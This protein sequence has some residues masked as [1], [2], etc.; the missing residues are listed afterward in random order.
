MADKTKRLNV[1]ILG[2]GN[3]GTDLLIKILRSDLLHCS[4]FIGRRAESKGIAKAKQ[5]GVKTSIDSIA[6]IVNDPDCCD[7]VF[8]CTSAQDHIKNWPIL[9]KLNKIVID[10]TPSMIGKK[11]VPS[12]GTNHLTQSTNVNTISCGGQATIPLIFAI[13]QVQKGIEYIEVV[14]SIASKSAGPSTRINIDEYIENTEEGIRMFSEVQNVK[15]ILIL[16][17]AEPSINMKTTISLK[18]QNPDMDAVIAAVKDMETIM[19]SYV[20]GF[21]VIVPPVYEDNRIVLSAQVTGL[22]DFL[23]SYAGNLDIINCAAIAT[24][25]RFAKQVAAKEIVGL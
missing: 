9:N 4:L 21:K 8:D 10:M 1:A 16:N 22:G 11:V 14:S 23:P 18:V 15:A 6:A 2:S 20:P 25:E 24:A 17:P 12:V 13:R 7:L 19:Q 3:I 5:L